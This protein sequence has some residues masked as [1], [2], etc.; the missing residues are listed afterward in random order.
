MTHEIVQY[1]IVGAGPA[2]LQMAYF[3]ERAGR[4]YVVLEANELAG[5][6]FESY[7][8]HRKL[9]SINKR[10]TGRSDAEFNLRHD[11]NS[12]LSDRPDLRMAE[13]SREYFPKADDLVRY[14]GSFATSLGL[15]IRYG[16]RVRRVERDGSSGPFVVT[17]ERGERLACSSLIVGTGMG[18][19]HVPEVPGI[20]L[21]EGYETMNLA[22]EEYENQS[23]LI[24]GKGN[25]AFETADHLIP[26]TSVI[27]VL[28][29]TPLRLAWDSRFVGHLRAVNNNLLD[30]YHLKSQNAVI[31]A[32][33]LS[34]EKTADG[35]L[36]VCFAPIHAPNESEQIEYDRVIRCTGFRF[37]TKIFSESTTP[38]MSA[39]GRLPQLTSGFEAVGVDDMFFIGAPMQSL[40]YKRTQSAFIHGFRYNIRSLFHLLERRYHGVALPGALLDPEPRKLAATILDRM[41]VVSSLWQQVGFLADMLI[42][43]RGDERKVRTLHDLPYDYLVE[44]G[45]ELADGRDFYVCMFR[46]GKSPDNP[47]DYARN[48]NPYEG[49]TSTEIHP[50]LELY[51]EGQLVDEFHV[52]EDFLADWSGN[53]YVE[54]TAE[55]L[56]HSMRGEPAPKKKLDRPRSIVRGAGMR[57]VNT[58][59]EAER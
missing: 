41:N 25:S 8:R 27:H 21:A 30:T 6:F 58:G 37:E 53:D 17:N 50:K 28:S 33:L 11:W 15:E 16:Q 52:L 31:D 14:L 3:L 36:R 10:H 7:P 34:I 59:R 55:F 44:H 42:L 56:A 35:K 23:V 12:L 38:K 51:R 46:I 39:C 19:P 2:G 32:E 29:P 9:L 47:F 26:A 18:A 5:S 57:L 24:L 4:S 49:D 43:P 45:P 54:S 1:C 22:L 40:D 20:E 48:S 13:F